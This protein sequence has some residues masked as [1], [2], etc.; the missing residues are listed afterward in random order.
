MINPNN[1]Y[2]YNNELK[3]FQNFIPM[4]NQFEQTMFRLTMDDVEDFRFP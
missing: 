1:I 2:I 4:N 3:N